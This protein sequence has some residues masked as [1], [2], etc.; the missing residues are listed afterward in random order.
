MGWVF[1]VFFTAYCILQ[2]YVWSER[3]RKQRK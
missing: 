1:F 2:S 3:D